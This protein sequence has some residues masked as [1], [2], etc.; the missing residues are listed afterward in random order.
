MSTTS[1]KPTRRRGEALELAILR[2]ACEE[3]VDVGYAKLTIEG[4][5]KRA[6]TSTPVLY[7]RWP[8]RAE[9]ALDALSRREPAAAQPPE[10][11]S[12]RDDL[13]AFLRPLARRFDGVLGET[14]RGLFAEAARDPGLDKLVQDLIARVAPESGISTI[15]DRAVARGE[16]DSSRLTPRTVALPL[17]LLRHEVIVRGTPVPDSAVTEIVDE[18]VLPL[19]ILRPEPAAG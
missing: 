6:Q 18:I 19:L 3:L 9:L 12:L 1:G 13:L 14:M 17:D 4:V 5:A 7:R 10:A 8:S 16:V 11:G 2:A 15:L